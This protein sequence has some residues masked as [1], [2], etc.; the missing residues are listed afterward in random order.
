MT[1]IANHD[2]SPAQVSKTVTDDVFVRSIYFR[3][4]DGVLLEFAGWTRELRADEALDAPATAADRERY[5]EINEK[6]RR[7][8]A[9]RSK[10]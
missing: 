1:E 5:L 8:W 3:D 6:A 7:A 10:S 2:S 9:A 4:P